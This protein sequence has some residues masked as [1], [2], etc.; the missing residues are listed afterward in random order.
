MGFEIKETSNILAKGINCEYE[1][2]HKQMNDA[3]EKAINWLMDKPKGTKIMIV[4]T[5]TVE[6]TE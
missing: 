4:E 5:T 1:S 6:K 3:M 2:S